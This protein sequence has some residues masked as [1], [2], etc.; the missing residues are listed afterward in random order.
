[1]SRLRALFS[2]LPVLGLAI[3][4]AGLPGR[5]PVA[6]EEERRAYAAA[7]VPLASNPKEATRRLES[8][9][10]VHPESPLVDDAL[11]RLAELARERGDV[12]S[13]SRTYRKIVV[14][15]PRG[16]R[17]DS[18][19]LALARLELS[20]GNRAAADSV[21]RPMRLARLSPEERPLAYRIYADL[22]T[23]PGDRLRWLARVRAGESE[24]DAVAG[25]DKEIDRA[26]VEMDAPALAR[27]AAEVG[28]EPPAGRLL[29]RVAELELQA[30]DFER[31][32][33]TLERASG[34]PL[35]P[36][37]APRLRSLEARVRLRSSGQAAGA[38][39][40]EALPTLEQ[41][42]RRGAASTRGATGTLGVVLP[43]S[44][45]LA[46]FGEESLQGVLLAAG[47]FGG[48]ADGRR[49]RVLIRDSAG[50]PQ[51]A[52]LAVAELAANPDVVGIVGPLLSA[53]SEAAAAAAAA[54][55]VPLVSLA[56]RDETAL[57]GSRAFRVRA[58]PREEVALVVDHAMSELGAHRFAILYPRDAYGQGL[59]RLFWE[60][61]E[62]RGGTIAA[63]ASYDPTLTDFGGAIRSLLGY[64][65]LGAAEKAALAE[66]EQ[67]RSKARRLPQAQA[68]LL[69]EEARALT[70]PDGAALPP[71]LDFD[72]IFVPDSHE[73]VVM[74]APQLAFHDAGGM[75]LLGTGS[76]NHPDL[77]AIGRDHVEGARF[78]AGFFADSPY[79]IV[80][81]FAAAYEEAY[82]SPPVDFAAQAY[83]AANLL[84]VQ[85]ARGFST[86]EAMHE[87]LLSLE[88]QP[89]VT[90]VLSFAG[91]PRK[92]PLL[93]GV[94]RGQIVELE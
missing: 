4:C 85:L 44:G 25:I 36:E 88:V 15:H 81:Q 56:A 89:G 17:A 48:E 2:L 27:A 22:A 94:D 8:F 30:G 40:L 75:R 62:E 13:A 66:R 1:V 68:A 33:R 71:I 70:G 61:V 78:S 79:P 31:A 28:P 72:A 7:L 57:D 26:M 9:V 59:R 93:L 39:L 69:L 41:A 24:P 18:A 20:R 10:A 45:R 11:L 77:V 76:W 51:R 50:D 67:M 90:G 58:L 54:S 47:V 60:A 49:V 5:E 35:V 38:A 53:E 46:R 6:S 83:D 92:R 23:D 63:V 86:R 87:G 3:A 65:L 64:E 37:D 14:E 55:G 19:R 43:L 52:A 42:S 16:D 82:G 91:A 74:I 80:Q 73:K 29:L 34:L 21:L 12:D 84:L 32:E